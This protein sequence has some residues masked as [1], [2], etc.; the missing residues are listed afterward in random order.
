MKEIIILNG[1]QTKTPDLENDEV[2]GE[3]EESLQ[4]PSSRMSAIIQ[5]SELAD[6]LKE[7]MRDELD[8]NTKMSGIDMR[9][10]IHPLDVPNIASFDS[11]VWLDF[12]PVKCLSVTRKLLR[13]S[14][15]QHGKGLDH[16]VNVATGKRNHDAMTSPGLTARIRN[17]LGL[18]Q[19]RNQNE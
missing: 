9:S 5:P 4:S 16:M 19:K 7:L 14:V 1:H 17:G 11:L 6:T 2:N 15:S 3:L 10:I 8:P 13:L 12:L 18:P